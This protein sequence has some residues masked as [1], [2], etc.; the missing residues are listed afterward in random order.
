MRLRGKRAFITAAEQSIG[1]ATG[2]LFAR[3]TTEV[4]A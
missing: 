2:M 3:E 1:R 4:I